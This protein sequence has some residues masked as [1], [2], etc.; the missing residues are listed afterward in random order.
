MVFYLAKNMFS[1]T[2]TTEPTETRA[3][4][5]GPQAA[6]AQWGDGWWRPWKIGCRSFHRFS[7]TMNAVNHCLISASSITNCWVPC[8]W[9][10][11][12]DSGCII[13]EYLRYLCCLE[14]SL[15]LFRDPFLPFLPFLCNLLF[16]PRW[17]CQP[18]RRHRHIDCRRFMQ[19]CDKGYP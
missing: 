9:M 7:A 4:R 3:A 14:Q 10:Y 2:E 16:E 15:A 5:P 1:E 18:T 8:I 11:L 12:D 19:V 17:S 13:S 6:R